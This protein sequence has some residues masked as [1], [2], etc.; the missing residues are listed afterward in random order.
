[1]ETL[2]I[3][4]IWTF[5]I[6]GLL[7]IIK[8]IIN[9]FICTKLHT[10]GIYFIIATKNQ[11][12]NIESFIRNLMFKIIYGKEEG[13]KQILVVDLNSEDRTK[14]II[15]KLENE[16][17]QIHSLNLKECKDIIENIKKI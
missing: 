5:A 10:E 7:E 4:T 17:E 12:N 13:I 3:I 16:Y 14:E 2:I 11:E 6:Y 9:T 15:D 8:N 1:M